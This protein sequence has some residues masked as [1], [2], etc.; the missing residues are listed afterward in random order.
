M[1]RQW[2]IDHQ[3][4][5]TPENLE[6]L[7]KVNIIPSVY[8]VILGGGDLSNMEYPYGADRVNQMAPV[9]TIIEMGLKPVI[10]S[11]TMRNGQSAPL[12]NLERF[13][14]R[15]DGRGKLWGGGSYKSGS[16]HGAPTALHMYTDWVACCAMNEGRQADPAGHAG[17]LRGSGGDFT[18]VPENQLSETPVAMTLV[19]DCL[20]TIDWLSSYT[21]C[22]SVSCCR[23]I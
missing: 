6:L 23:F 20:S 3:A 5:E 18:E 9:K 1:Q 8:F 7:K 14:T 11:D 17:T 15:T 16:S 21:S 10:E 4:I 13:V 2:G 12:W 22:F 19:E